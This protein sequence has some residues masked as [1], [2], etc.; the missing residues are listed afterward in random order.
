M[1]LVALSKLDYFMQL[2]IMMESSYNSSGAY[3]LRYPIIR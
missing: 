2:I 1:Y 3:N